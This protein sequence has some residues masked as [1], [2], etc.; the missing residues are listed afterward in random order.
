V[1]LAGGR[2]SNADEGDES[3][4]DGEQGDIEELPTGIDTGVSRE[5]RLEQEKC[6]STCLGGI[7]SRPTTYLIHAESGIIAQNGGHIGQE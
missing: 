5:I 2:S 6:V 7:V 1:G 4:D 3:E